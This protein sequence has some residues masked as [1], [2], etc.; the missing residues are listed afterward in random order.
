MV[1]LSQFDALNDMLDPAARRLA[2]LALTITTAVVG[3]SPAPHG[4]PSPSPSATDTGYQMPANI[5][6]VDHWVQ[7]P[8]A[9]LMSA[10]GTFIR[11]FAEADEVRIFNPDAKKGSYPGFSKAD[12][13]EKGSGGGGDDVSGY[14]LRWVINFAVL[15]DG[16]ASAEVCEIS[17][18][19]PGGPSPNPT[20][21]NF[22]LSYQRVGV[23][24][25]AN[26][27]GPARAPAVSVFG[28]WYATRYSTETP[29]TEEAVAPC[30][31]SKPAVGNNPDNWPGWPPTSR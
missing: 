29:M 8:A 16:S 28:D 31:Q 17:S 4:Y 2:A 23:A 18:I 3:C 5:R 25:P 26:Q 21:L 27:H 15:P 24:P 1:P 14:A 6:Y 30:R 11:S 22:T 9:D 13:T 7:T 20:I 10:D 12:R 19:T